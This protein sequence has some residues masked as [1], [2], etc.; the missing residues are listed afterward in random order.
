MQPC[1]GQ[2]DSKSQKEKEKVPTQLEM[3]YNKI[4]SNSQNLAN[5]YHCY[6]KLML[7]S[8]IKEGGKYVLPEDLKDKL[9]ECKEE[10][11]TGFYNPDWEKKNKYTAAVD[12][13]AQCEHL[14]WW[15]AHVCLGYVPMDASEY[16]AT[17]KSHNETTMQ[18]VCMV[19]WQDL[20]KLN[21]DE[22]KDEDKDVFKAYDRLVVA[23]TCDRIEGK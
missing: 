19:P 21:K 6:T 17:D 14:R 18:H 2:N 8:E 12:I 23:V 3:L 11:Y 7:L 16:F 10:P 22:N 20:S 15:A 9:N 5:A 13:I 1:N 4:R